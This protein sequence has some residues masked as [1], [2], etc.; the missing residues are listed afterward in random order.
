MKMDLLE[1]YARAGESLEHLGINE[2]VL[3]RVQAFT[4]LS[5]FAKSK[6]LVLGGD[7]YRKDPEQG[8]Y[9]IYAGWSYQGSN[10]LE[11]LEKARQHLCVFDDAVY[12]SFVLNRMML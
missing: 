12:V 9:N 10:Y 2:A 8:L 1:L 5:L 7:L 6:T 3:P 4:A 11:G